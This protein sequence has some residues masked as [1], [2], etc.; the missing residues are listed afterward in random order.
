MDFFSHQDRA[1][2]RTFKLFVLYGLA[3]LG[4]LAALNALAIVVYNAVDKEHASRTRSER[5][6]RFEPESAPLAYTPPK[7]FNFWNPAV[8]GTTSAAVLVIIG[9][10]GVI[11]QLQ[12]GGDGAK[13]A[14]MMGGRLVTGNASDPDERKFVNVVEEMSIASGVPVPRMYI[15]ENEE[16]INA[17]AAGTRP[18]TA[19]VAVT[20]GCLRTLSRD[21]LQ[22]VVAHEFSHILNG[23]MR[24]NLRMIALNF[25]I[26]AIGI[27][28]YWVMRIGFESAGRS[29]KKEGGGAAIG[30]GL[31]GLG[32]MIIGYVGVFFGNLVQAAVSRQ[33]EFLADASAVQFTR[34]PRGIAGALKKI[35]GAIYGSAMKSA[36][37]SEVSHM[38]FAKGASGF[39]QG[40]FAT[41]P[42]LDQRIRAIEPSWNGEFDSSVAPA[43]S[44]DARYS[45]LGQ[46]GIAAQAESILPGM[47]AALSAPPPLP[48]PGTK[49]VL[50]PTEVPTHVAIPAPEKLVHATTVL[51]AIPNDVLHA[52]RDAYSARA[53]ALAMLINDAPSVQQTQVEMLSRVDAALVRDVFAIYQQIAP[54]GP[55]V[56][57]PLLDL[58]SPALQSLSPS[59]AK[60]FGKLVEA[61]AS[62]DQLLSPF[63]LA[64]L[65]IVER[66]ASRGEKRQ[67]EFASVT[68]A[69]RP[70]ATMLSVL[71][72]VGGGDR[73]YQAGAARLAAPNLP[74]MDPAATTVHLSDALEQLKS[75]SPG[76]QRRLVDAAAHCIAADGAVRLEE[77]ELLRAI[78]AALGVPVPPYLRPA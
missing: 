7:S 63:E 13:V 20:R 4:V 68:A 2:G 35:G 60:D 38:C 67:V 62:A 58:A 42:P 61:M 76:V 59:Q 5:L 69:A 55:A 30:I 33:R 74:P 23:D 64:L 27:I 36:R 46:S 19:V 14:E 47:A 17:F 71:A 10:A 22:G 65:K 32:L 9:L 39:M 43:E 77:A 70:A 44:P 1:R 21:E 54:L 37:A 56:R 34:N 31:I 26:M 15:M 57:V 28:G 6:S 41:H 52:V 50:K 40:L 66:L 29:S 53:V 16:G 24:I 18:E 8:Y 45:P 48:A 49:V 51:E 75:A 12:I 25:G 11:K 78:C 72:R 73:A 3:V